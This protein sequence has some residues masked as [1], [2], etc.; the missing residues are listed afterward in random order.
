M[1][2]R[3]DSRRIDHL[4]SKVTELHSLDKCQ[5]LDHISIADHLRVSS[6]KSI[7]ICPNLKRIGLQRCSQNRSRIIRTTSTQIGNVTRLVIRCNKARNDGHLGHNRKTGTNQ[8]L[9][10]SK[11]YDMFT[12]IGLCLNKITRIEQF[13]RSQ[14]SLNN[15]RRKPLTIANNCISGFRREVLDQTYPFKNIGQLIKQSVHFSKYFSTARA[16]HRILNSLTMAHDDLI[17]LVFVLHITG[18]S[19]S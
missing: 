5:V 19:H 16:V 1:I 7:Y 3:E 14:H 4:G 10:W 15:H 17:E 9:C 18:R 6:H 12:K 2:S 13:G 8:L 11:L